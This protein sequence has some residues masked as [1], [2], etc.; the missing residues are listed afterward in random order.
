[1]V[2]ACQTRPH[3]DGSDATFRLNIG[4]TRHAVE[5]ANALAAGHLHH[6][7]SVAITGDFKGLFREDMFAEGQKLPSA[8]H[9]TKY[10]SERVVRRL[11]GV[12]GVTTLQCSVSTGQIFARGFAAQDRGGPGT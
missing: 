6:M 7:S 4:G 1:M 3:A 5:L 11:A 10:E 12:K 9:R 2:G 8:Y